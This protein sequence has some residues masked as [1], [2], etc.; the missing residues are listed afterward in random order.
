MSVHVT[1]TGLRGALSAFLGIALYVGWSN[2]GWLPDFQG[3]G[4]HVFLLGAI[5][6]TWSWLGFVFLYRDLRR[7]EAFRQ[8][9]VVRHGD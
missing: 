2:I 3:I 8:R 5:I 4:G 7:L 9:R 1:L 6:G